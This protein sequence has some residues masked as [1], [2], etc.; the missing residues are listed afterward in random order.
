MIKFTEDQ[1]KQLERVKQKL[2]RND[3]VSILCYKKIV[4]IKKNISFVHKNVSQGCH[5]IRQ[6]ESKKARQPLSLQSIKGVLFDKL[7]RIDDVSKI[8][9]NIVSKVIINRQDLI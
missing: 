4:G 5:M 1:I 9:T 3:D 6:S 8:C 7:Q 2:Q